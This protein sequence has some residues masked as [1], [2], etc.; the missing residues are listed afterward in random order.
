[1][2]TRRLWGKGWRN[3]SPSPWLDSTIFPSSPEKIRVLNSEPAMSVRIPSLPTGVCVCKYHADLFCRSPSLSPA[4]VSLHRGAE[5]YPNLSWTLL[6]PTIAVSTASP[7]SNSREEP[8]PKVGSFPSFSSCFPGT[9][10]QHVEPDG[11][12]GPPRALGPAPTM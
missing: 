1:M 10:C 2:T 5:L 12:S 9:G 6:F 3:R 7:L 11:L 8:F 4:S